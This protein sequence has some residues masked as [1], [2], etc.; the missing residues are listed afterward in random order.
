MSLPTVPHSISPLVFGERKMNQRDDAELRTMEMALSALS[1]L[2]PEEQKRVLVWLS[3]KLHLPTVLFTAKPALLPPP[4]TEN[5]HRVVSKLSGIQFP[6]GTTVEECE[7]ELILQTLSGT[8]QNKTRAAEL[9][10]ISLKTL[11]NKLNSFK[12]G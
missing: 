3:E 11:H 2:Q 7:R 8:N 12:V 1:G 10:G 6:V 5:E 9:L 4:A